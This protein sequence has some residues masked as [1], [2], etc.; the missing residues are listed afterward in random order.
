MGSPFNTAD[1]E[2]SGGYV[3]LMDGISFQDKGVVSQDG[4]TAFLVEWKTLSG[5]RPGFCVW[6]ISDKKIIFEIRSN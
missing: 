5:N 3:P 1:V 6:R 4:E 2:L